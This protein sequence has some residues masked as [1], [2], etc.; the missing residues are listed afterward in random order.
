MPPRPRA[1]AAQRTPAG[2]RAAATPVIEARGISKRFGHVVALSDVSLQLYPGEVLGV[3]GDNGAGKSTLM[4]CLSGL[5]PPSDGEILVDGRPV[6]LGSP[7]DAR[8]PG[9]R[10]GLPGPRAGRQPAHRREHLPRPRA[11]A[12][13]SAR[14]ALVDHKANRERASEHLDKLQHRGQERRPARRGALRRPA[15]GGRHRPRHR[16]RGQGR[17][18][19]R[20]DRGAGGARR[21]RKVLDLIKDLRTHGISVILISHRLDD[22][23]YV[24]DRVMALFHGRNFAEAPLTDIDRNE[25]IGWIMG[26]KSGSDA[27]VGLDLELRAAGMTDAMSARRR[28]ATSATPARAR[29]GVIRAHRLV[30]PLGRAAAWCS[31]WASSPGWP[32]RTS[33]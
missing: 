14:C 15:P 1:G 27:H 6:R 33:S 4:K 30:R 20:A 8:A 28:L 29:R 22:I 26:N 18:H 32:S 25:V 23:F 17:H 10:D 13:L 3:V 9:H 5:H 31:S 7:R 11:D 2:R 21:S 12:A 16:L 19:G 24:C